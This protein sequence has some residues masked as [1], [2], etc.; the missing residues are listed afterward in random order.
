MAENALSCSMNFGPENAEIFTRWVR[1][2]LKKEFFLIQVI[3]Y[4]LKDC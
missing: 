2:K 4:L 1:E 3:K